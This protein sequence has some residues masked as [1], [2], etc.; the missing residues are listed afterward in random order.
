MQGPQQLGVHH[1]VM[2]DHEV[3]AMEYEYP[4]V[5]LLGHG[6]APEHLSFLLSPG[7]YY[8]SPVL[9]SVP[10]GS[11]VPSWGSSYLDVSS[12]MSDHLFLSGEDAHAFVDMHGYL[13]PYSGLPA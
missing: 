9:Y 11:P 5:P 10:Y 8:P 7:G 6:H 13:H 1:G 4:G 12:P 2:Y 3:R